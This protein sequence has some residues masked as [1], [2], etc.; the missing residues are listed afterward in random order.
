MPARSA[1]ATMRW[2][3]S[4]S[5][6]SATGQDMN[7]PADLGKIKAEAHGAQA[8]RSRPSGRRKTS[9]TNIWRPATT[10]ISV[11]WSGSAA[12]SKKALNLP[13][14]FVVPKEGAIGWFD[15]LTIAAKARRIPTARRSS[16]TSWSSP[17]FYVPLGHQVGA[18]ASANAKANRRCCRPT[19]QP[20]PCSAIPSGQALHGWLPSDEQAEEPGS[21]TR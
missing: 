11:Y 16:S 12:R 8:A 5:P 7:A 14:D 6:R 1:G 18:P 21:G 2:N 4:R 9:G 19:P 15:G 13:V 3:R 10:I 17:E 20:R